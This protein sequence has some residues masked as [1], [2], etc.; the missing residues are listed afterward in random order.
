[1]I[2]GGAVGLCAA[3]AEDIWPGHV[4]LTQM[5]FFSM[6][7]LGVVILGLWSDLGRPK[8]SVALGTVVAIHALFLFAIRSVFPFSTVLIVIPIALLEA[9]ILYTIMLKILGTDE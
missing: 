4:A 7:S 6:M 2:L 8:Y 9:V 1:M 5:A 3:A